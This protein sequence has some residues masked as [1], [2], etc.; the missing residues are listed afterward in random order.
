MREGSVELGLIEAPPEAEALRCRGRS[1]ASDTVA[2][3]VRAG[4]RRFRK[5]R[6]QKNSGACG[7]VLRQARSVMVQRLVLASP[8]GWQAPS[9]RYRL[10]P[11]E[12]EGVWP[13][14]VISAGSSPTREAI[15][16]LL[17]RGGDA[18]ALILQR[19]L[20]SAYDLD[21]LRARYAHLV[22]DFDDA[23][24]TVPPDLSSS[25]IGKLPKRVARLVL[26]GSP[27]SSA[28][29]RPLE[30]TLRAVD[31]CVAGNVVLA[32]FARQFA[33]RV[34]E[35]P[36][37]M[38]PVPAP[39]ESR[40]IPP[41]VVWMG[42]PDN[43]Q[44]LRLVRQSLEE[45]SRDLDFRVRIV[46]SRTWEDSPIPVE[47]V[48]WSQKALRESLLTAS[49][50]LAP[51]TDDPWTRGKC[52]FRAIQYGGHALPTVA[53]PVGITDRVVLHGTTGYLAR[54]SEQ[55]KQALRTLLTDSGRV[56]QMGDAALRH[57]REQ[58]SDSVAIEAWR[59]LIDSLDR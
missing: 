54:S 53:S 40:A 35:I 21:R 29:K 17:E 50:G 41:V 28:R 42:L 15:E 49:V 58:Y 22:F 3:G 59:A 9:A 39:P 24:Y 14:D 4:R 8:G 27:Y 36:T 19:A 6:L 10:G 12:R 25:W 23:V 31:V 18:A 30:R 55:W 51:L 57:I 33:R 20:P 13:I 1:A 16:A 34:T 37:T 47:F 26:R 11:L 52:A 45:L 32:D 38:D 7:Q 43:L 44:H 2:Q 5:P 46:S 56:A 48:P